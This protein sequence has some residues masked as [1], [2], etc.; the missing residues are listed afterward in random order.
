MPENNSEGNGK[1]S[2][3]KC[4]VCGELFSTSYKECPFCKEDDL[5]AKRTAPKKP[6]KGGKRRRRNEQSPIGPALILLILIFAV[7]LAFLFKGDAIMNFIRGDEPGVSEQSGDVQSPVG[8][9]DETEGAEEATPLTVSTA[10]LTV[11]VG[12]SACVEAA[13]GKADAYEWTSS[14]ESILTVDTDGNITPLAGGTATVTV[15]D[16]EQSASCTVT[17]KESTVPLTVEKTDVSISVGEKF[18]LGATGGTVTYRSESDAIASVSADGTVTGVAAG[19]T[20][21]KASNGSTEA[22][23]IVRVH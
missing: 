4:P 12:D 5:L 21:V 7:L 3:Y 19:T 20:T 18:N 17:V 15:S 6:V 14:D 16:G 2:M 1:M 8:E 9:T 10:A 13:G 23:C 11:N 22:S